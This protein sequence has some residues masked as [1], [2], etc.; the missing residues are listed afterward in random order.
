MDTDQ[1]TK[2][3]Q[4][5]FWKQCQGIA[6]NPRE[7]AEYKAAAERAGVNAYLSEKTLKAVEISAPEGA[8][9]TAGLA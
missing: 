4:H 2:T 7:I 8:E 5:Y 1:D 6:L 9:R 3:C